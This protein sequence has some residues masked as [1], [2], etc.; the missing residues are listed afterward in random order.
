MK[1]ILDFMIITVQYFEMSYIIGNFAGE[2][3]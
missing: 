2:G 1:I 3:I